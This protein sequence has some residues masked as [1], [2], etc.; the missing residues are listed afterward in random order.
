MRSLDGLALV[1]GC[2]SGIGLAIAERLLADGWRVTGISRRSP[3]ITASGFRH[4]PL[5]LGAIA[6]DDG[7]TLEAVAEQAGRPDAL[8][9]AAGIL[10]VGTLDDLDHGDGGAM[11]RLHVEAA[12]RL[13]QTFAPRMPD[14]GRIVLIG[15]RVATGAAGKAY[16]AASKAALEGLARSFAAELAPRGMTVN[17]IAP[18]ATETPMLLDPGRQGLPPRL[19]PMGR[20]VQPAEVAAL[21]AFLL[22]DG[23][24]SMT[25]QRLVMCAGSSL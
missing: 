17:V 6:A 19:P 14:G 4:I 3:A 25:G 20:F 12:A 23:G 16:Y 21:A 9:H 10:K 18:A 15:S 22:G 2:S 11:W 24:A 5:D 7:E 1:T 8:V 13:V